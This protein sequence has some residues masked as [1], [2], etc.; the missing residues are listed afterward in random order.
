MAKAVWI[1]LVV[2]GVA[3]IGGVYFFTTQTERAAD[4]APEAPHADA[5]PDIDL[6]F[7]EFVRQNAGSYE[8][9]V[10]QRIQEGLAQE[11]TGTIFIHDGM[12]RGDYTTD[13]QGMTVDTSIIVRDDTV[14]TWTSMAP[15]GIQAPVATDEGQ[16]EA[17]WNYD[18]IGSYACNPATVD[19][20]VFELPASIQ[21]REV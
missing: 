13:V 5:T 14:Y 2:T 3:L 20:S 9:T 12:I 6:S 10:D 4:T 21:F 15:F 8:C 1:G 11:T 19:S 7:S 18:S 16:A 17:G